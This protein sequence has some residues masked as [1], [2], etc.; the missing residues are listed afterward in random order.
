MLLRSVVSDSAA[1]WIVAHQAPVH[2]IL[3]ARTL[4]WVAIPFPRGSSWP[5]DQTRVPCLAGRF[6]TI[7][8]TYVRFWPW[9]VFYKRLSEVTLLYFSSSKTRV[10]FRRTIRKVWVGLGKLWG[11]GLN[12]RIPEITV[13]RQNLRWV[14]CTARQ[15][16]AEAQL[17]VLMPWGKADSSMGEMSFRIVF[18]MA[19]AT[20][21]LTFSLD[22]MSVSW[23]EF[24]LFQRAG[25][26]PRW[27]LLSLL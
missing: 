21:P 26:W 3:Q 24:L 4:E 17:V 23:L 15:P 19:L 11:E 18:E 27:Q 16:V 5:R 7:W 1:P 12:V 13:W 22:D 2:G 8:A 25:I 6:L 10:S 9:E 20:S 14:I